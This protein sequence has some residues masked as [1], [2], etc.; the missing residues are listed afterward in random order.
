MWK[1]RVE[2]LVLEIIDANLMILRNSIFIIVGSLTSEKMTTSIYSLMIFMTPL[3]KL[4][5][6]W[7]SLCSRHI[8]WMDVQYVPCQSAIGSIG[9][10][11]MTWHVAR[12]WYW[13]S[14]VSRI[15]WS[16][17]RCNLLNGGPIKEGPNSLG[18]FLFFFSNVAR[19]SKC[20]VRVLRFQTVQV[21]FLEAE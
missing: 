16:I 10:H 12:I 11:Q 7:G 19:T 2:S 3:R 21:N 15:I 6:S 9:I 5:I 18:K 1:V 17:I 8:D 14:S 4:S 20:R 13:P